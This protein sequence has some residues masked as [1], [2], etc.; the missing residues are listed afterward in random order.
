MSTIHEH[1][2][3]DPYAVRT[4]S[5]GLWLFH[6]RMAIGKYHPLIGWSALLPSFAVHDF[7][8]VLIIEKSI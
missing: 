3:D 1:P 8:L 6:S 7:G 5:V 2:N 4:N